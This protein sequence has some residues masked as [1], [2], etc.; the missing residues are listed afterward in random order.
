MLKITDNMVEVT[1]TS[2]AVVYFTASWCQ[3][4]KQ[5]KPVYAKAGMTDEM[6]NYFVIDVDSI[7]K[8]YLELYNIKSVP[9]VYQMENG[10]VKRQ[11]TA[12]NTEDIIKQVHEPLE[13]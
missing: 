11:I 8:E 1:H 5:L 9:T 3:P 12:R 4:C 13:R 7:D 10:V 2:K 6:Y